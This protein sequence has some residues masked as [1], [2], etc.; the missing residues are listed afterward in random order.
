[1]M[2]PRP[3]NKHKLLLLV[4]GAL[5]LLGCGKIHAQEVIPPLMK[6]VLIHKFA[7]NIEWE[8]EEEIDTF[9]IGIYGSDPEF[10]P[11]IR[12]LESFDIKERP[13]SILHFT[14]ISDL[15]ST[16]ILYL[17]RDK[18]IELQR[19][20]NRIT[21]NNTLIVSDRARNQ[22]L[23][24]I[25]LLPLVD[26]KADFDMNTENII[27]ANLTVMP[28]LL[29][30]GGSELHPANLY[31]ES[32]KALQ[33][34][35]DQLT[36]LSDSLESQ[37]L[38]IENQN[39]EIDKRNQEIEIQKALFQEKQIQINQ[40]QEAMDA[41]AAQ[42]VKVLKEVELKQ[43][44]LDS[45]IELINIQEEEIS[46]QRKE[47]L[48]RNYILSEQKDDITDHE[49]RI[50]EQ[51]SQLSN[52]ANVVARQKTFLYIIVVVFFLIVGLV[53]FI[54]RGYK[55]KKN[56]NREIEGK[57]RE[58]RRRQEEILAQSEEIQQ[59]NEEVVST[60][61][62]L[63]NQKSELQFTL[64]NLKI[65]QSQL[66]QSEKMASV[67]V[68][69][70]GIAHELNNPINFVSGNVSPLRRDVNDLFSIIGKYDDIIEAKEIQDEF[71][72]VDS[73]KD[74][75]D[76]SFM[77]KEIASLLKGIEEGALRSSKIVKGLR[78]FSR[79]D[80]EKC[81]IYDIHEGIDSSLILLHN[82]IKNRIR[83][84]KDYGDFDLI[85]CYPSKFNQ[86]IMN[87]L[88]NSIQAIEGKGEIII[89]TTGSDLGI[90]I[91]IKDSGKGMAPE[92]K[93]HIFEPFFTTKDVGKGTGLGLSISFGIIEQHHGNIDVIS[94]PGKGAEFIISLPKTQ[95]D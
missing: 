61:E 14:R 51:K 82:K 26:G 31:R 52:M 35:M 73:L 4:L 12:L 5:I 80:E 58:L 55:I 77:I 85:E 50:L 19:V 3:E 29:V 59:A 21:G 92:V 65:A 62:A 23:I 44:T 43:E 94:E 84:Q 68:L 48:T 86:V 72:D 93:E 56:A 75:V 42:L 45:K 13:V 91:I 25:N 81:Q 57:N 6:T 15:V 7:Q 18:S 79:L 46:T 11:A 87:I 78:S 41:N 9:R 36:A 95:P 34:S 53:F 66:I 37:S 8:Q 2:H 10:L 1:M 32:Q 63:E 60:N 89:Q 28:E 76:Y 90:K 71:S 24:M 83:V 20:V 67:G 16:Q 17:A 33:M 30:E 47:I 69:T 38:Q 27:R 74:K 54:Y 40:Q 70:A 39:R 88:T 49:K 22:D 64:E